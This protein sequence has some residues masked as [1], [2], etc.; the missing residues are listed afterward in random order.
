MDPVHGIHLGLR[1]HVHQD[2]DRLSSDDQAEKGHQGEFHHRFI[3]VMF[4]L[5]IQP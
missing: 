1:L 4:M 5:D 2:L 3:F